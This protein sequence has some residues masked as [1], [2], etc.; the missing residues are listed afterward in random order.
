MCLIPASA[1]GTNPASAQMAGMQVVV[2]AC[3]EHG[4]VD[5]ADLERQGEGACARAR[6]DHGHLS[7]DA[8]RVR[9]RHPAASARSCMRHGGQVYVDGA[10]LNA[11]V[12]L[13]APGP[14]RRRRV[15]PQ[16]AQD[17]LH[18][19]RRRRTRGGARRGEGASRAIPSRASRPR[20]RRPGSAVDRRGLRRALRQRFD[21]ADLLDVHHDDG[22]RR[23]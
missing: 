21:P 11:M 22:R 8:R 4:N 6:R 3:D 23:A 2:V 17:V 9:G 7:V 18:P 5:L 1:H 20:G 12:G 19:A 14:L 10:N 15:A 13:A 16:P